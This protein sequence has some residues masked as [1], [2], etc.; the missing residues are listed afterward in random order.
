VRDEHGSRLR[1]GG[2]ALVIPAE[3][4]SAAELL[5]S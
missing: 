4:L 2:G 3:C 5:R 1:P